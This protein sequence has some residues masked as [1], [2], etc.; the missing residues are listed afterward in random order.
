MVFDQRGYEGV[1][2][3]SSHHGDLLDADL[4]AH[5]YTQRETTALAAQVKLTQHLDENTHPHRR[6]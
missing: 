5:L 2:V 3:P 6:Q 4:S 1:R